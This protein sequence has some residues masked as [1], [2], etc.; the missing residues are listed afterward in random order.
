MQTKMKQIEIQKKR[1]ELFFL[2]LMNIFLRW[3]SNNKEKTSWVRFTFY[4][5][6]FSIL[7]LHEVYHTL[8]FNHIFILPK[9]LISYL[10]SPRILDSHSLGF[11]P[12]SRYYSNSN[13]TDARM[14]KEETLAGVFRLY[15]LKLWIFISLKLKSRWNT[16]FKHTFLEYFSIN[17]YV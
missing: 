12:W 2:S 15:Q 7:S 6:P 13:I 1:S 5:F 11:V 17:I 10:L 8:T 9:N 16:S 3:L 14:R 4:F